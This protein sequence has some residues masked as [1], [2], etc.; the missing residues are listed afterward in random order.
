MMFSNEERVFYAKHQIVEVICQ[1]RFP[2]ILSI[3]VREPAEFQE[4]I[5]GSYP[6]YQRLEEK[7]VRIVNGKPQAQPPEPNYAF[8]SADNRWKVNLTKNFL[9]FSTVAYSSWE[10]FARRLD[11]VLVQFIELYRPAFFERIGLR[12][13]NAFSRKALGLE[14]TPFS[15][16]IQPAYLGL[17]SEEDVPEQAFQRASQE[18]EMA[19]PGGCRLHLRCGPGVVKRP[20]EAQTDNELQFLLDIDVYMMG[21]IEMKHSAGA[22]NTVHS[23]AGRIFRGAITELLHNAMEPR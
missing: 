14:G 5:R 19:L 20:N 4:K 23:N 3:G 16:L 10:D 18:V 21:N 15:E 8:V 9:S 2:A 12:Y 1:L 13:V 17:M 22:L 7:P 11:E 6:L